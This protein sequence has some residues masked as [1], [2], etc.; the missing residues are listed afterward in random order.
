MAD[1]HSLVF[2]VEMRGAQEKD[3]ED[4]IYAIL[5]GP[6][7]TYREKQ[8]YPDSLYLTF[9]DLEPDKEYLVVIKKSSKEFTKKSFFTT[10]SSTANGLI[11]AHFEENTVFVSVHNVSLCAGEYYTLIAKDD[12]G[13]VLFTK[14]DAKSFA[15]Y[16][17][18]TTSQ[19]NIYFS[20]IINDKACA[21][22]TLAIAITS[23]LGWNYSFVSVTWSRPTST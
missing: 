7:E 18:A 2:E 11:S 12:K 1:M 4:P 16:R 20:L 13:N 21:V 9:D 19:E 5:T 22:S 14:D 17:F 15:E 3:F 8:I 6:E 23:P 10:H